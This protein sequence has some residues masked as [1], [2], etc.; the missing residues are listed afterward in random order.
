VSRANTGALGWLVSVNQRHYCPSQRKMNLTIKNP[1]DVFEDYLREKQNMPSIRQLGSNLLPGRPIIVSEQLAKEQAAQYQAHRTANYVPLEKS[2]PE[3]PSLKKYVD[4]V[5]FQ[6]HLTHQKWKPGIMRAPLLA[7]KVGM[8]HY[9]DRFAQQLPITVLHVPRCVVTK[10]SPLNPS[11]R[12]DASNH[13]S[14]THLTHVKQPLYSVQVAAG[15]KHES[16]VTKQLLG[17]Y[18]SVPFEWGDQYPSASVEAVVH[19]DALPEL[20]QQLTCQHFVPGQNIDIKAVTTG[21]GFQGPMKR[22]GFKGQSKTHGTHKDHRKHGTTG[23]QGIAKTW[24]GKKMAGR[25]GNEQVTQLNS[26]IFAVDPEK[27]TIFVKGSIP[28]HAGKFV[29]LRDAL[30]KT[31]KQKA[32]LPCPTFSEQFSYEDSVVQEH[33]M[34]MHVGYPANYMQDPQEVMNQ[35][36]QLRK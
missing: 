31:L 20:G 10:I 14:Y 26:W 19:Q 2:I 30:R 35:L 21:K 7:V 27:D 4:T 28:G 16:K 3:E 18:R 29:F 36:S 15:H 33:G 11:P 1:Y 32:P 9:W 13:F 25:M 12:F 23:A 34:H 6:E 17:H 5:K 8:L 24:K 22:W